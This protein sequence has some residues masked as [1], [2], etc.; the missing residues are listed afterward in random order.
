MKKNL[1]LIGCVV[2]A[3]FMS[4]C[5]EKSSL[6]ERA[7][8]LQR[9]ILT[10]D[11]HSDTPMLFERKSFDVTKRSD[12]CVDFVKMKE[13]SLDVSSFAVFTYQRDEEGYVDRMYEHA[14]KTYDTIQFI[15]KANADIVGMVSS[16]K[17]MYELKKQGKLGIMPTMENSLPIGN[18][19]NRID[20]LYAKGARIFGLCHTTNNN[21]CDS[22]SDTI[23]YNY[24]GG[25]SPFGEQVVERLNKLGAVVD[26]SHASDST[27]FD[28]IKLSK[29]P[30][31]ASHSSVRELT[32]HDRNFSDEMLDAIKENGGTVQV[33][34]VDIFIKEFP[35]NPK[36]KAERDSAYA[37]YSKIPKEDE[38]A[39]A[40]ARAGRAKIKSSYPDQNASIK[41]YVDHIDYIAKRIGVDHVGIGTDFD[42]GGGVM[43]CMDVSQL[44]TITAELMERGYSDEDIEKIWSGN[45]IR[46]FN[47]VIEVSE[48]MK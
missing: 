20:T 35:E 42:G 7:E 2:C 41:D 24:W 19:I 4:S 23:Q 43:D 13:G 33:C 28:I 48:S 8:A 29:A 17:D 22:S 5:V 9:S 46:V 10:A 38:A 45:L 34:M 25:L 11:T 37:V 27:F 47:K 31:V 12:G 39:R 21:I 26:V 16:P 44:V 3:A 32:N 40:E 15:A 36:Y 18:D 30:I 6:M 1:I 14:K